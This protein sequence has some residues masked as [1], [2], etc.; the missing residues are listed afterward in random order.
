[1][2]TQTVALETGFASRSSPFMVLF[3]QAPNNYWDTL[4]QAEK[5]DCIDTNNLVPIPG[6][7]AWEV[8]GPLQHRWENDLLGPIYC[9]LNRNV[10]K[11]SKQPIGSQSYY[12]ERPL[13]LDLCMVGTLEAFRPT[14]VVF[15]HDHATATRA[16]R[17]IKSYLAEE[18]LGFAYLLVRSQITL[19]MDAARL[20]P[21]QG[22]QF[23]EHAK[24]HSR[25]LRI[26]DT[27][28]DVLHVQSTEPRNISG[29]HIEIK[30]TAGR[31]FRTTIGGCLQ[32]DGKAYAMTALHGLHRCP[33]PEG[34]IPLRS[35]DAQS[36]EW[37]FLTDSASSPSNS[38]TENAPS[39]D[40]FL[41]RR[42]ETDD[43]LSWGVVA[44]SLPLQSSTGEIPQ[45]T[46]SPLIDLELDLML[47]PLETEEQRF[48]NR[49]KIRDHEINISYKAES[50]QGRAVFIIGDFNGIQPAI[51]TPILGGIF[52][53]QSGLTVRTWTI[54]HEVGVVTPGDCGS[55]IV[56]KDGRLYGHLVATEQAM[57]RS[58]IVPFGL[59]MTA[60]RFEHSSVLLPVSESKTDL[61]SLLGAPLSSSTGIN[62]LTDWKKPSTG[63][64]YR[65]V[66]VGGSF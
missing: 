24:G 49:V 6:K 25:G 37:D 8:R 29:L 18:S 59:T 28:A 63:S 13:H 17:L 35:E 20:S 39:R 46:A 19:P 15:C 66:E 32:V 21:P 53:P 27:D 1:M 44:P 23:E 33:P 56:D 58:Y 5:L 65:R 11:T 57:G 47:L 45:S 26:R 42:L 55:W 30:T 48:C 9:H 31:T 51:L 14:V 10:D 7:S 22:G 34:R 43:V 52:M 38:E 16:L 3:P 64:P 62:I 61:T 60:L 50:T 54:R 40:G 36:Q 4:S 12:H 2:T 41:K